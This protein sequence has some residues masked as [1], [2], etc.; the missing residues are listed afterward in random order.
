[1]TNSAAACCLRSDSRIERFVSQVLESIVGAA[2]DVLDGKLDAVLLYGSFGRGEASMGWFDGR[3]RLFSDIDA[4][5]LT[6]ERIPLRR[7]AWQ[8][9]LEE[10]SRKIESK[11]DIRM[12]EMSLQRAT[13]LHGNGPSTVYNY[14]IGECS[15]VLYC[16]PGVVIQPKKY[17]P[18]GLPLSEGT[19][20]F[21]KRGCGLLIAALYLLAKKGMTQDEV[22]GCV[23]EVDKAVIA[24]GDSMLIEEGSYHWSLQQRLR[25]ME[26]RSAQSPWKEVFPLYREAA[27]NRLAPDPACYTLPRLKERWPSAVDLFGRYFLAFES[28][29]MGLSAQDWM[30]YS[31]RRYRGSVDWLERAKKMAAIAVLKPS[32]L[33]HAA[34]YLQETRLRMKSSL[35]AALPLLLF[36][37]RQGEYDEAMLR[38]AAKLFGLNGSAPIEAKN[39]WQ[40]AALRWVEL[41]SLFPN[42]IIS[43]LSA[44]I[45]SSEG[46]P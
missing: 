44:E 23:V 15:R 26:A 4:M 33:L 24:V 3:L 10:E 11:Y 37:V 30:Q 16:R 28:A 9:K 19:T 46:H 2:A 35:L 22:D 14:E 36:S 43:A 32:L 42:K 20:F 13:R 34:A 12:V 8:K 5:V 17:D 7:A 45:R 29:R 6:G 39:L 18:S 27:R 41:F 31:E 40:S 25:R 1:M 21:F 38:R